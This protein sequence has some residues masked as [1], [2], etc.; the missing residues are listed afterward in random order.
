M[1]PVFPDGIPAD[2]N[3][4]DYSII[5]LPYELVPKGFMDDKVISR[6]MAT[7]HTGIF[8]KEYGTIFTKD[9]TGFFK[10]SLIES[11]VANEKNV[12]SAYWPK[13][14]CPDVFDVSLR[15]QSNR[16]YILAVD[17]ASESDSCA[18]VVIELHDSHSRIVYCWTTN[19]RTHRALVKEGMTQE[20]DF[21][22]FCARKIRQL[23]GVFEVIC[24]GMDAQ[25]GGIAIMEALH[26]K[27]K[28]LPGEQKIWPVVNDDKKQDTD[29]ER[30]LH[31]LE[32]IQ[33][34]NY[35]W[36]HTANHGMRKDLE[37]RAL[38]FPRF[39]PITI[40]RAIAEDNIRVQ[41][42][43]AENPNRTLKLY[44][45]L[46]DAVMEIEELKNELT[47]IVHVQAGSGIMGKEKW[48]TPETKMISGKKG[49]LRK[50][51]YSAL[52]IANMLARQM[53]RTFAP[54]SYENIGGVISDLPESTGQNYGSGPEWFMSQVEDFMKGI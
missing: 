5:R 4:R 18:I 11:C 12:E 51:R 34:A 8:E 43:E 32:M 40:E 31:M 47:T 41:R 50:D 53:R 9:S 22:G 10:R 21:Y 49:R 52:V 15:G 7:T 30:G 42:F 45:T 3:W 14:T 39:D 27:D 19:R 23:M 38:L 36:T 29:Y 1:K 16:Q 13:E 44:D 6:A 46:E 26:D 37:D 20:D 17:P 35:E 48:D 24:I 33:F 25:G 28:L 54:I 2:F